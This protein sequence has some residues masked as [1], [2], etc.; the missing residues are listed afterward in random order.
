MGSRA[1][2]LA[3]VTLAMAS[4][5]HVPVVHSRG[6]AHRTDAFTVYGIPPSHMEN[7]RKS[8]EKVGKAPPPMWMPPAE[9]EETSR[10]RA[11]DEFV[12]P[13]CRDDPSRFV[14]YPIR[15]DG[16]WRLYKQHIASFWTTEEIDLAADKADWLKLEA[17]ERFFITHV[18][19]FFS[20][21]DG[22]VVENL[23]ERFCRDVAVPEARCFYG[24]QMA[25]EN[26]H[27]ETYSL[28]IQT[29]VEDPKERRKL[30]NAVTEVPLV[31]RKAEWAL[32]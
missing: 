20:G 4:D 14:L 15:H 9:E 30:L 31:K 19:A 3:G 29:Y 27:A 18:L 32:K 1:A 22:I 25:M 26:V 10:Q 2:L 8:M 17:D 28:L 24:F 13:I 5:S 11:T 12:E 16:L 23:A 6:I 7:V 21:S